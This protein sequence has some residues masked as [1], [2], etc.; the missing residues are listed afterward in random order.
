MEKDSRSVADSRLALKRPKP[1]IAANPYLE[2]DLTATPLKDNHSDLPLWVGDLR[3]KEY[4][5]ST[6][7]NGDQKTGEFEYVVRILP[8][9]CEPLP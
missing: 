4:R 1:V 9:G 6:G 3:K 7:G 8:S 2:F 5:K